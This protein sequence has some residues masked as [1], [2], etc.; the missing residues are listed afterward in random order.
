MK[1]DTIKRALSTLLVFSLISSNLPVPSNAQDETGLCEHHPVHIGCGFVQGSAGS[2]CSHEHSQQCY[3]TSTNCIHTHGDCG[4]LE[5]TE[6]SICSHGCTEESGC[7]SRTLACSHTHDDV[8]GYKD[9]VEAITCSYVCE[10][11]GSQN[12]PILT[13]I[14]V[15]SLPQKT[16][17][18][19]NEQLDVSGG[20]I[21]AIYSDGTTQ[22]IDMSL[23]MVSGFNNTVSCVQ[24]LTVSYQGKDTYYDVSVTASSGY[25]AQTI[26]DE[27][28][29]ITIASL[30]NKI[31][32]VVN[33]DTL[34]VSGGMIEVYYT[35]KESETVEMI[36]E[37]I[38]GFD[39][40]SL[41]VQLLTV[42]YGG[43]STTFSVAVVKSENHPIVMNY[44]WKSNPSKTVYYVGE[45]VDMSGSVL[46]LRYSNGTTEDV[47]VTDEMVTVFD[48]STTGSRWL[49]AEIM[50]EGQP[51]GFL[52][53]LYYEVVTEDMM[54]GS[55]GA[56]TYWRIYSNGNLNIWGTGEITPREETYERQYPWE[57]YRNAIKSVSVDYGITAIPDYAFGDCNQ[58]LQVYLPYSVTR[59]GNMVFADCRALSEVEIPS[60]VTEIGRSLFTNC[61]NLR[62]VTLPNTVSSLD[63]MF[64]NCTSL[65][66][67]IIPE[68]I[69]SI[70]AYA[71]AGCSSLTKIIIPERITSIEYHAFYGC[72]GLTEI[73]IPKNVNYIGW[74]A[75]ENCSSLSKIVFESKEAPSA[76]ECFAGVTATAY[77]PGTTGYR[78]WFFEECGGNITWISTGPAAQS[79]QF[80]GTGQN[81]CTVGSDLTL[82]ISSVPGWLAI[83]C[84]FTVDSDILTLQYKGS[85]YCSLTAQK[86]GIATVTATDRN[87]G[88]TTSKTIEVL[89]TKDISCPYREEIITNDG[90][91]QRIYSFTPAE[92]GTY[93]LTSVGKGFAKYGWDAPFE[94][95]A[96]NGNHPEIIPNLK[97]YVD[98]A[99]FRSSYQLQTGITYHIT[100]RHY[101]MYMQEP[102][103]ASFQLLKESNAARIE[104]VGGN[105]V[106]YG[107]IGA[108]F[109]SSQPVYVKTYPDNAVIDYMDDVVWE[110][111]N[112]GLISIV[113]D[114]D[115]LCHI[116]TY[117]EGSAEI[118]AK[119]GELSD[120]ITVTTKKP[121]RLLLNSSTTKSFRTNERC[122]LSFT[123]E[124][125]GRYVFIMDSN[126][127][128]MWDGVWFAGPYYP[129]DE[130]HVPS[131]KSHICYGTLTAGITYYY[132]F[133][134]HNPENDMIT[135]NIIVKKEETKPVAINVVCQ[136][137][138]AS[139]MYFAVEFVPEN[140]FEKIVSWESSNPDILYGG[141]H[142]Y[143]ST[144]HS[145]KIYGSGEVTVTAVTESGKRVKT[146]VTVG[147]CNDGHSF[148]LWKQAKAKT[149]TVDGTETATCIC[150]LRK[151][152]PISATGHRYDNNCDTECNECGEIRT[153]VHVYSQSWSYSESAHWHVCTICGERSEIQ[154]HIPGP[155][156]TQDAPQVC[157]ECGYVI[158]GA[159]SHIHSYASELTVDDAGHW[160]ACNGCNA[161]KDYHVHSYSSVCDAD[162]NSC[163]FMRKNVHVSG[164]IW[165]SDKAGHWQACT[166]CNTKLNYSAHVPGAAATS[167]TPQICSICRYEIQKATGNNVTTT[168]VKT[169]TQTSNHTHNYS[170]NMTWNETG[171]WYSCSGCNDKKD[172]GNHTYP[173]ACTEGCSTCG[174][175]RVI[176]H[177]TSAYWSSDDNMHWYECTECGE[178]QSTS[179]HTIE[180]GACIICHHKVSPVVTDS[181]STEAVAASENVQPPVT[182]DGNNGGSPWWMMLVVGVVS[183]T[184]TSGVIV[185]VIWI[186]RKKLIMLFMSK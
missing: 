75:F 156:A 12:T 169:V 107:A 138:S 137:A 41:G 126:T 98:D 7:I 155:A 163:G 146:T 179:S 23:E 105:R 36:P 62:T 121:E 87:S 8:C 183:S 118:T 11:C 115:G 1:R 85:N 130:Y 68:N 96:T 116:V 102:I 101:S 110:S 64:Q 133:G 86:S 104:I 161:R 46:T 73:T 76:S 69:T 39:N 123:P 128:D 125:T 97:N 175:I 150:G 90:F 167:N 55:C 16:H 70:D 95:A 38:S 5:E 4:Y 2:P 60:S 180:N 25:I 184:V 182:P 131:G 83:D 13:S 164:G 45:C 124:E 170:T 72:T 81:Q 50:L 100:V 84:E 37:M 134:G 132:V 67:L 141:N 144:G 112:P 145:F 24:T 157:L 149:C 6:N 61:T 94:V 20:I 57:K 58:L 166:N 51:S 65:S 154:S 17:Y 82:Y 30:P 117:G 10:Q 22:D 151:Y 93:L 48:T 59:I 129:D 139:E 28:S 44:S 111:S 21:K 52:V 66:E 159:L 122:Y 178:K 91:T 113:T 106:E 79:I 42:Q 49:Y 143:G 103:Q 40:T 174:F 63:G 53:S 153:V 31:Q 33:Q 15:S 54:T 185:F 35:S 147:Q 74:R 34:D 89:E 26:D 136:S 47:A 80:D 168:I 162:C 109:S 3:I 108:V 148:G 171:H 14:E 158:K 71:F 127:E 92:N 77:Y 177:S 120:T 142:F 43:E 29:W 165:V 160:Y 119:S 152:R 18:S 114:D 173:N 176:Q 140:S 88:C 99:G 56:S 78:E 32:Y 181:I 27:V 186:N 135:A 9:A 172:Y 19:Q